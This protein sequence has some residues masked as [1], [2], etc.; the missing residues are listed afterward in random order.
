MKPRGDAIWPAVIL[1]ALLFHGCAVPGAIVPDSDV[2]PGEMGDPS[3]SRRVLVASGDTDFK[4][5]VAG[6][7]AEAFTGEPVYVRFTGI[8]M[9]EEEDPDDYDA[10]V[11][12]AS[13]IA[14]EVEEE[15][16]EYLDHHGDSGNVI[17]LV[18]SGDG[19]WK[20]DPGGRRYDAIA[21][22]SVKADA[23]NV[24]GKVIAAVRSRLDRGAGD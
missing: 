16:E 3:F 20:P 5:E 18:T 8:G 12:M 22:A 4:I 10:V 19:G 24:A 17:L 23:G 1:T 14:W 11:V 15:A 13:C 21:T 6:K 7:I 9:L 2:E